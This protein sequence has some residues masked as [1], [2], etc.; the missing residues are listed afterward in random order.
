MSATTLGALLAEES[1][2]AAPES[3]VAELGKLA[4]AGNTMSAAKSA[5]IWGTILMIVTKKSTAIAALAAVLL[6]F[7]GTFILIQRGRRP[8]EDHEAGRVLATASPDAGPAGDAGR[9]PGPARPGPEPTREDAGRKPAIAEEKA[10]AVQ[11]AS[12]SGHVLDKDDGS[13]IAGARVHVEISSDRYGVA[14]LK[15]YETATDDGGA[16]RVSGMETFGHVQAFAVAD[17]YAMSFAWGKETAAGIDV[18]GMDIALRKAASLVGGQVVNEA[19]EPVSGADVQVRYYGYTEEDLEEI[20]AKTGGTAGHITDGKL[21]F[22]V[23]DA[24]GIFSIALPTDGGLCDLSVIK[25]GLAAGFFPR[26]PTGAEDVTLML[27]GLAGIEGKVIWEDGSPAAGARVEATGWALPGGL[28]PSEVK[29]QRFRL[30]PQVVL[31]DAR[32]RYSIPGASEDHVYDVAASATADGS[33]WT[34]IRKAVGVRAGATTRDIDLV[35][36][37]KLQK[38]IVRGLVKSARTG[39]PFHPVI[40][41]A[42]RADSVNPEHEVLGGIENVKK[43]NGYARANL[44]LMCASLIEGTAVMDPRDLDWIRGRTDR[45][46]AFRIADGLPEGANQ[47]IFIVHAESLVKIEATAIENAT[48]VAHEILNVGAQVLRPVSMEETERAVRG[49]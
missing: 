9:G 23:T 29:I 10:P 35:L 47:K 28:E 18:A 39:L 13:A 33:E 43:N 2:R 27:K 20:T 19:M 38:A 14:A 34:V 49:K 6:F 36:E 22:D 42:S 48:I 24:E 25:P 4:L 8:R 37:A 46:G 3:L 44:D 5:A 15:R 32:G 7:F 1:A 31:A 21:M 17:G 41:F 26:I 11:A 40:V 16:Y 45:N 30:A 12:V